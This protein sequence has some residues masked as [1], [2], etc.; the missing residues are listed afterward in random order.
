ML[1]LL[2]QE[3]AKLL[4][5]RSDIPSDAIKEYLETVDDSTLEER[6]EA[7]QQLVSR[8][9]PVTSELDDFI[10]AGKRVSPI[11]NYWIQYIEMC[12]LL[13]AYKG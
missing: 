2:F 4:G 7:F 3:F 5:S 11:F 12:E 10:L 13:L 9:Q 6:V 8:L 1:R